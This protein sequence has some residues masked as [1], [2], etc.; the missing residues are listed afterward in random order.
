MELKDSETRTGFD[1]LIDSIILS[2]LTHSFCLL[3]HASPI[4]LQGREGWRI[5]VA[6]LVVITL[7]RGTLVIVNEDSALIPEKTKH[8]FLRWYRSMARR[9][10]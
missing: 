4:D 7:E 1:D 6:D 9:I 2:G 5:A 10:S 8:I 3:T